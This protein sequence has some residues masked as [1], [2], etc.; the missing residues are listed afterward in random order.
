[1][2]PQD[3]TFYTDSGHGWLE[4]PVKLCRDLGLQ[5]KISGFS[6]ANGDKLYLEEDCDA[7]TFLHAMAKVYKIDPHLFARNNRR[8]YHD[9]SP[10]RNYTKGI[11]ADL[12][13]NG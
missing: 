6:Y 12:L 5:G 4:V 10:I 13:K 3:F 1:M 7:S 9:T 8:V 2:N 11:P